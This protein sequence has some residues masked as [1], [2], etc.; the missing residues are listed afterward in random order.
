MLNSIFFK[1]FAYTFVSGT[2]YYIKIQKGLPF[3]VKQLPLIC[4]KRQVLTKY[5]A[6]FMYVG[7]FRTLSA[8]RLEMTA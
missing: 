8:V 1:A 7:N 6:L 5:F 4:F 2:V 3:H